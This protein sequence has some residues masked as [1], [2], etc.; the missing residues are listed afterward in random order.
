MNYLLSSAVYSQIP[1][2]NPSALSAD[3]LYGIFTNKNKAEGPTFLTPFLLPADVVSTS[4]AQSTSCFSIKSTK[5]GARMGA[6]EGPTVVNQDAIYCSR[7]LVTTIGAGGRANKIEIYSEAARRVIDGEADSVIKK[8][9]EALSEAQV[10]IVIVSDIKKT[11]RTTV[12]KSIKR[13]E[14]PDASLT[15]LNSKDGWGW[16]SGATTHPVSQFP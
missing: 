16:S 7:M 9:V 6:S 8:T 15:I 4:I 2:I 5:V 13:S 1:S 11:S 12:S 3:I 14:T 10:E